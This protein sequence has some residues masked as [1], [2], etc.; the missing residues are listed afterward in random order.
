M[1][2]WDP[3]PAYLRAA[4]ASVCAQTLP[5]WELIVIEDPGRL[6]LQPLL[7]EFGDPRIRHEQAPAHRGLSASRNRGLILA[8]GELVAIL[9]ADDECLP[10][11]L[12]AQV[13]FLDQ[14][15]EVAVVGS[16]IEVVDASSQRLGF[17]GY[18]CQHERIVRAM[19]RYNPIAHPAVVFRRRAVLA[20]GGY[21]LTRHAA[22]DDYELW[23]RLCCAGARFANLPEALVRYRLHDGAMKARLAHATLRDTLLIKH[24]YFGRELD[25][26]DRCRMLAERALLALP[27]PLVNGLF[28]HFLVRPRLPAVDG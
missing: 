10:G 19:R 6:D 20:T 21:R 16:Q 13:A 22:C 9:D 15:R 28:R 7:A 23:S 17:R 8:R 12:A 11:R 5:E 1:T 25:L 14:H 3:D 2:A 18:P 4:I 27:Q 26:G 24:R